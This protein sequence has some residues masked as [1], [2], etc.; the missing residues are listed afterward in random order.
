MDHLKM[1]QMENKLMLA[2]DRLFLFAM[3]RSY[4]TEEQKKLSKVEMGYLICK[5]N[6]EQAKTDY[7]NQGKREISVLANKREPRLREQ[8]IH[9][10]G[11]NVSLQRLAIKNA[12]RDH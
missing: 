6:F 9:S 1:V 5:A 4:L 8:R 11:T 10:G 12:S 2:Y 7:L 3:K